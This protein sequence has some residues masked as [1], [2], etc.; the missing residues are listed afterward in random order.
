MAY[1]C[2][3]RY[4]HA[5]QAAT[6][7]ILR[8]HVYVPGTSHTPHTCTLEDCV[9][10]DEHVLVCAT[11]PAPLSYAV[12]VYSEDSRTYDY[13]SLPQK[14]PCVQLISE[15]SC[16]ACTYQDFRVPDPPVL[17]CTCTGCVFD[18]RLDS[19]Y[20]CSQT[21]SIRRWRV[22]PGHSNGATSALSRGRA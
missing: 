1:T 3:K 13:T 9:L 17:E 7:Y 19:H 8:V 20:R 22:G 14:T 12:R 16:I 6:N 10:E 18:S 4:G 21:S 11:A 2:D 15:L 5:S